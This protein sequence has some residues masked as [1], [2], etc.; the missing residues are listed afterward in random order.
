MFYKKIK[1]FPE[2]SIEIVHDFLNIKG[3]LGNIKFKKD[4][5]LKYNVD[6][7]YIYIQYKTYNLKNFNKFKTR[8][9]S[10]MKGVL[11]GFY[12]ILEI[13]GIGYKFAIKDNI[14]FLKIGY[15]HDVKYVI[16]SEIILKQI[17]PTKIII[18]SINFEKLQQVTAK[19]RKYKIP[20]VYK[21]KGILYENEKIKLKEIRK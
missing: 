9:K 11:V 21:G 8:I 1:I 16:P 12:S 6:N 7:S 18:Q 10:F 14:L 3:P 13:Q 17:S 19:I 4:S 20:D 5:L 15:N 2:V